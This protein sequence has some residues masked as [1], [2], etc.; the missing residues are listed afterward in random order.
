MPRFTT[1]TAFF[2]TSYPLSTHQSIVTITITLTLT[3]QPPDLLLLQ[4]PGDLFLLL[5]S[6]VKGLHLSLVIFVIPLLLGAHQNDLNDVFVAEFVGQSASLGFVLGAQAPHHCEAEVP[7]HHAADVAAQ[8]LDRRAFSDGRKDRGFDE[9]GGL[10]A[11]LRVDSRKSQVLPNMIDQNINIQL[12]VHAHHRA[13][14]HP[15][16]PVDFL[17]RNGVDLVVHVKALDVFP[18]P[19]AHVDEVI[20]AAVFA[21]KDFSVVDLVPVVCVGD[22]RE[23]ALRTNE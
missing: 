23:L 4:L 17:N 6:V 14:R 20:N 19:Q 8:R 13:V 22:W 2:I 5:V 18:V 1:N 12:I 15:R 21:E 7:Q 10:A 9:V 16:E 11:A 3:H